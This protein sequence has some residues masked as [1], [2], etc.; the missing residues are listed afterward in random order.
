MTAVTNKQRAAWA[1][2]VIER[3]NELKEG[4]TAPF[5]R[6]ASSAPLPRCSS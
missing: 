2:A 5:W 1:T 4:R 6:W 3:Y